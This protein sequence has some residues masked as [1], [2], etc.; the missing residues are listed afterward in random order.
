MLCFR[1]R[2]LLVPYSE[3][4]LSAR[5]AARVERHLATC[6]A[7][8]AELKMIRSVAR[9]L[10]AASVPA[11]E[12]A[13]DLW[14]RVSARIADG[15]AYAAPGARLRAVRGLAGALAV[16]VLV[17]AVGVRLLAPQSPPAA[18]QGALR[19][20]VATAVAPAAK[21]GKAEEPAPTPQPKPAPK[22][23]PKP[24]PPAQEPRPYPREHGWFAKRHVSPIR[25]AA[26]KAIKPVMV[27]TAPT[28]AGT[29]LAEPAG[30]TR[31]HD[32][33]IAKRAGSSANGRLSAGLSSDGGA[34]SRL[35]V[36]AADELSAIGER[37][38]PASAAPAVPAPSG[39]PRSPDYSVTAGAMAVPASHGVPARTPGA[40]LEERAFYADLDAA[41]ETTTTASTTSVVDDLNETEGV[42]TAAIFSYP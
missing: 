6:A 17:A 28:V 15:A 16:A 11:K 25:V 14:A 34:L 40:T 30:N 21:A 10:G 19:R 26:A 18:K 2:K 8:A 7:C 9:E 39:A 31:D 24:K 37:E 1:Y 36:H 3:A 27:A 22:P 32:Y 35:G 23:Q 41:R 5:V 29:S 20:V 42:R 38:R 33:D 13:P 12:P 4:G